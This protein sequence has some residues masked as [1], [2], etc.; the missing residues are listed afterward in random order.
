MSWAWEKSISASQ[1]KVRPIGDGATQAYV[2]AYRRYVGGVMMPMRLDITI[3]TTG[4]IIGFMA[5]NAADPVLP[6][7]TVGEAEA[8]KLSEKVT[9]LKSESTLLVAQQVGGRWLPVWLVGSGKNDVTID[10]VTG[11]HVPIAP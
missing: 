6:P 11:Q 4:R 9:G 7:V 10:A 3:T 2:V 1:Q 5:K 8:R